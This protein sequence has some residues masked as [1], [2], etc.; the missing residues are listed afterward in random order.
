MKRFFGVLLT[1]A[2]LVSMTLPIASAAGAPTVSIS[3][4]Q[5]EPGETVTLTVSIEDNPGLAACMIY[6]YYD[7]SVFTVNPQSG[8]RAAGDFASSGNVIGNSIATAKANGRYDGAAGKDGVLALWY[9]GSGLNTDGDGA[10]LTVK[11]TAKNSAANGSYPVSIGYS[12]ENTRNEKREK[13]T[14]TA[15]SGTVNLTVGSDESKSD[16]TPETPIPPEV[17]VPVF[18]DAQGHWAQEYIEK[19]AELGLILGN[20][21]G[22]Y[23]PDNTMSRAECVTILWRACGSPKATKA[24]AFTD[25]DP[26]QKWYHEAVAWSA[27]NGV[28]KGTG[29]GTTFDPLGTVNRDQ[30]ATILHRMAG[31]PTPTDANQILAQSLYNNYP[32]SAEIADWAREGLYWSVYNKIY[33]GENSVE[34]ANGLKPTAAANRAQIAVMIVR[35]L[36]QY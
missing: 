3:S 30:L 17:E 19:A 11:M 10:M 13:V 9:N 16:V 5:V 1:V 6:V 24:A 12:T 36:E 29:D 27:E 4:G 28:I 21:Y 14:L 18:P 23:M 33:C 8:V 35:Y 32:D 31:S 25:L 22:M 15:V 26:N 34:I 7:T 20:E 2:L